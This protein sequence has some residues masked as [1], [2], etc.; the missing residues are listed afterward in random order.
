MDQKVKR[1]KQR[2]GITALIIS[3][4]LAGMAAV[5]VTEVREQ[6]WQQSINTILEGTRQG[7]NTLRVQLQDGYRSMGIAAEYLNSLTAKQT[8]QLEKITNSYG[9]ED[10]SI[11]LYLEDGSCYPSAFKTEEAVLKGLD[12]ESD[13]GIIDPHISSITG[14]NV[15][16][17]YRKVRLKDKTEGY[18][19]KEF[20]VDQ[21]VD[22]FSI[23]FYDGA[24]FSYV[25]D[26]D[27]DILIRPPHPD[28][29]KT[30]QNLF[31][32]LPE[33]KNSADSLRQFR[34]SLQN[35]ET[36]WATF[37]YMEEDTVFGFIPLELGS[38]WYLVSIIPRDVV[39][40]QT[41][42]I[43]IRALVLSVSILAG[44]TLLVAEYFQY[45]RSTNR[46][47]R[48]QADYI[49]HLYNAVPV[50]IAL[51][52]LEE[53]Y[54]FLQ[55]NREGMRL[56][57]YEK[58][59]KR[60]L[61]DAVVLEDYESLSA[62]LHQTA[63]FGQKQH[64]ESRAVTAEGCVFWM[65]GLVEKTL[66]ETGNPILIATFHDITAEKLAE[67]TAEQE[68]RQERIML[69]GAIS[70]VYPVIISLNL[71]KDQMKFIYVE[72]NLM[73]RLGSE[74]R[75]SRLYQEFC[76]T[77]HP[78]HAAEFQ[79]RFKPENILNGLKRRREISQEAK[80]MLTDGQYHWISTQ[81]VSV[82]NPYSDDRLAILLSRRIDDQRYEEEQKRCALQSALENAKA[83][84][85]AKS[86]F[87]SNMS[88]DIR[89]PMNA[90]VGM[91]A[92]AASHLE[93]RERVSECLKKISFSSQHLLSLINDI[94]D[95]SKIESGK[96]SVKEEP[97]NLAE[98][99]SNVVE[100]VRPQAQEGGLDLQVR[101]PVMQEEK[102]IGDPLRIR[103]VYL[104]LLSNA[105]KYTPEGGS[106]TV[107]VRQDMSR[108]KG[109]QNYV[110]CCADTGI[111]MS[112]EFLQ[113]LYQP[114]E[115]AQDYAAGKISGTGLGLAI[116]KNIVDLMGGDITVDSRPKEGSVFTVTIPLRL[117]DAKQEEI[118][119]HWIG[120]RC[121]IVDDD[122][123]TCE[124]TAELLETIGLK[125][126]FVTNGATAVQ[127]VVLAK[128][129]PDPFSIIIVDWK[130]P[131]MDGVETTR[132][133]RRV[134]GPDIPVI[135]LTAYDWVDIE[136]EARRAGVTAFM[137]KPFY[138]SKMCYMLNELS[139]EKEIQQ[140]E[141]KGPVEERFGGRVLLVEDNAMNREIARVLIGE[142]GVMV[143]EACNGAEA[144]QMMAD[145]A[146]GYY[147]LILMDIQMPV[148]DG[149][150]ATKIIRKL[151]RCDAM[152]VPIVAMTA[153]AFEEDIHTAICAGMNAHFSKPVD[154][155]ELMNL[156]HRYLNRPG[157]K[158]QGE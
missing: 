126:E 128:Q 63:V 99:V 156:L 33:E 56:L 61:R 121:L 108:Q 132:Q 145:S 152:S 75:Y 3:A 129:T 51:L 69:V 113:K 136:G 70:S 68:K 42:D 144:V 73:V 59:E 66:D 4:V 7:S 141:T 110:F 157:V 27:G 41:K 78:D 12:A 17:L 28:S 74:D 103:Q 46:R 127:R 64:F 44:I 139:G 79:R 93:D 158:N 6:L 123:P 107:E 85:V 40:A 76:N 102:V 20:E 1:L 104:N 11:R 58:A 38:D 124:N 24:G 45:I 100:L 14:V 120:A 34:E 155:N 114:F 134:V 62:V 105:V 48:S 81:I 80:Y 18:L 125:A 60:P 143:E 77:L 149:Y 135:I 32:M 65:A 122:R 95:M 148:M 89:T 36:G 13:S 153:N 21:I 92:I 9:Q 53:P 15:F 47:L 106:V 52:T 94:L 130:L 67:E 97:F 37:T 22:S 50:G 137:A 116:T 82:E 31:D 150:E 131:D 39:D 71:T 55:L 43:L 8:N 146:E 23:S 72:K 118:V 57:G 101:L 87:L 86:R 154:I 133:I 49:G 142:T 151:K 138:R 10:R 111:G 5:F 96:L 109:Y 117:Q 26:T 35:L 140:E 54:C 119:E 83:A 115:R 147:D 98:L 2:V 16:N 84:S 25:M 19:I 112:K 91:T 88:H 30:V 90:I 29:N